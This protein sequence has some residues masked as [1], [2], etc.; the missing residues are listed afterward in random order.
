VRVLK[1]TLKRQPFDVM[2]TGEKR[3]EFRLQGDWIE[4]RLFSKDGSPRE[5]DQIEYVNGYGSKRPRFVTDFQGF[6]L[7]ACGVNRD[8]SNGLVIRTE[9]PHYVIRHSRIISTKNL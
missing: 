3:E 5:Y 6:E 2:V 9:E 8:Y 1:L 7:L 4:S